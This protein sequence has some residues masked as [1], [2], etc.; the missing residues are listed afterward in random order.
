MNGFM[1]EIMKRNLWSSLVITLLLVSLA[2]GVRV[3]ESAPEFQANDS[4]GQVQ[5]LSRNRG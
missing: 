5:K 4:N 1:E 2:F 3:G